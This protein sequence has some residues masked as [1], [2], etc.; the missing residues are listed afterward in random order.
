M[1]RLA[2]VFAALLLLL[3]PGVAVAGPIVEGDTDDPVTP[4]PAVTRPDTAH[5]TVT[6]ADKFRSNAADGTP[7]FYEGTLAPPQ[8]CPGP[9]AKVVLDQ[10][11]TVSGRQFDRIG[12][13][14]IGGT[15]VWWGT[16]EEPSGEGKR[17]IRRALVS[18]YDKTGL[19]DLAQGLHEAGVS[20]VSTGSTAKT[21]AAA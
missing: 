10:T 9:W 5:C 4:A 8:A 2:L 3:V 14:Q 19:A 12:D 18:V 16:T 6:L 11:V 7:R 1:R 15:E 21:I 17:P 13:L 20:I